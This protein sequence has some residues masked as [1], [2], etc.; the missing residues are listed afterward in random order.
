M[1]YRRVGHPAGRGLAAGPAWIRG[2]LTRILDGQMLLW[3]DEVMF[4]SDMDLS[5]PGPFVDQGHER[6][7]ASVGQRPVGHILVHESLREMRGNADGTT[8]GRVG[9]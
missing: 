4:I 2:C 1:C 5:S 8:P 3:N 6:Y 7:V 9:Q